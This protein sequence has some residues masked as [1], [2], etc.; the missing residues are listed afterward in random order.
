MAW[1]GV[2]EV[3]S[4]FY[5]SNNTPARRLMARLAPPGRTERPT[6]TTERLIAE[7]E[8]DPRAST[9]KVRV[10]NAPEEVSIHLF[11]LMTNFLFS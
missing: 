10:Q 11:F 9:P 2:M 5:L 7:L 1:A 6:S 8:T 4:L 3:K